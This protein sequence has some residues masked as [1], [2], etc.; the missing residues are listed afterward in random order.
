[1]KFHTRGEEKWSGIDDGDQGNVHSQLSLDRESE[2]MTSSEDTA[3]SSVNP[4]V[5]FRRPTIKG[6][7]IANIP[8]V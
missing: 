6:T 4:R 1:M 7:F 5:W 3:P 2:Q 8:S